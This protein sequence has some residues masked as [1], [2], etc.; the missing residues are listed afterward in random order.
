MQSYY[1]FLLAILGLFMVGGLGMLAF[2]Q[3]DYWW[4]KRKVKRLIQEFDK[5]TTKRNLKVVQGGKK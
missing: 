5:R 3:I 1:N 2:I 4:N